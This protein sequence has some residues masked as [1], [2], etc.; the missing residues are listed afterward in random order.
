[1]VAA[2]QLDGAVRFLGPMAADRLKEPL[3]AADV[4]VLATRNE[5]WANVLLEA[6]ACGLPVV[7]TDVGGNREV[8]ADPDLGVVIPFDDHQALVNAIA[9]A[10]N[11]EWDREAIRAHAEANTWDTRVVTLVN[12]FR[13]LVN[14]GVQ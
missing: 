7:V 4:F 13:T 1:M 11:K 9:Q 5:G 3:S 10:L 6:M 14:E 2:Q 12:E 8:V